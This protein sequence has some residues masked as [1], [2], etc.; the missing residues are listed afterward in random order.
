MLNKNIVPIAIENYFS[1]VKSRLYKYSDVLKY[2]NLKENIA[3]TIEYYKNIIEGVYN[4][5]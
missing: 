4:R 3:R 1:I 5:K 2:H